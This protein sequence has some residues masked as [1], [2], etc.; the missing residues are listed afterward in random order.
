MANSPYSKENVRNG[1]LHY[2]LGRGLAG[3]AGFAT[4]ILLVR[5][6]D[7]QSYAGFTALTGLIA[8]SG[9]LAGLGLD[10]AISR[11]VPEA[12][13]E[14]SAKKLGHFIWRVTAIKLFAAFIVS[15]VFY[16]FWQPILKLFSD[17]HL[18][19]FPLA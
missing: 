17:V 8:L 12:R 7:V 10:R 4:V 19:H 1:I 6:M 2:L 11:Y 14:R 13:L 16:C 3:I 5:F 15:A 9:I 18:T